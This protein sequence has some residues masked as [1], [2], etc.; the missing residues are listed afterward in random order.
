MKAIPTIWLKTEIKQK[1]A[2]KFIL[3]RQKINWQK[4]KKIMV[5]TGSLVTISP[6]ENEILIEKEY[7]PI[8]RNYPDVNEDELKFFRKVTVK[9]RVEK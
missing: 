6:P 9:Q 1:S 5:D 7:L 2:E 3:P 8:T 4:W